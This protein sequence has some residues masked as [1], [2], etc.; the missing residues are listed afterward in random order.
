MPQRITDN[1]FEKTHKGDKSLTKSNKKSEWGKKITK[2][3]CRMK[4]F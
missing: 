4:F 1:V 3:R 2:T